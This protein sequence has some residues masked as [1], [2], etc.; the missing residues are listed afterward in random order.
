MRLITVTLAAAVSA[1]AI[2]PVF[3]DT[4]RLTDTQYIAAS[5]CVGLESAKSL[6][7]SDSAALRQLVKN[8]SWG[9]TSDVYDRADEARDNGERAANRGGAE[10][11]MGLVAERDGLCH[12]FIANQT[13][14]AGQPAHTLQ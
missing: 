11:T 1:A 12:S 8:Q 6:A 5:R 4:T 10:A 13:A 3:A 2:T 7:S 9:R 14:S